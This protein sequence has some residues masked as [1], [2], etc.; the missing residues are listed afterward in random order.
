MREDTGVVKPIVRKALAPRTCNVSIFKDPCKANN[1]VSCNANQ[2]NLPRLMTRKVNQGSKHPKKE[3]SFK[4]PCKVR[5][6]VRL[7]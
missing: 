5:E 4:D 1:S 6:N 2:E 3:K 7:F